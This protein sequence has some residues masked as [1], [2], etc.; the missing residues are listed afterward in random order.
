MYY[1]VLQSSNRM[2]RF[3]VLDIELWEHNNNHNN[4]TGDPADYKGPNSGIAKY[5]L[6]DAEVA[7]ESDMG[8]NYDTVQCVTHWGH[9]IGSVLVSN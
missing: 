7:R 5:A 3:V 1:T 9:L 6:A 8:V 4:S 2:V